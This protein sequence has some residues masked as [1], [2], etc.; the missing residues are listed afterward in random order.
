MPPLEPLYFGLRIYE[1]LTLLGIIIG[2][3]IA[4]GIS[5]YFDRKY[6]RREGMLQVL[7][8][9]INTR[10]MPSDPYYSV[11]I[12]LIPLEFND[13]KKV[14]DAWKKFIGYVSLKPS[15]ENAANYYKQQDA[16]QT[17]LIFEITKVLELNIS[18]TEIQVEAYTSKGYAD[19]DN[20]YIDSLIAMREIANSLKNEK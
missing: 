9:L 2:P 18:E 7:R 4:V 13:C 3:I 10:H 5:I 12:N 11:A 8:M 17:K 14:M 19:R 15:Q 20:L 6:K 16:A 1:W